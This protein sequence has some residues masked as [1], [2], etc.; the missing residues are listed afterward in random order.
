MGGTLLGG[1]EQVMCV[2]RINVQCS[3]NCSELMIEN[4]QDAELIIENIVSTAL[5]EL[6]DMVCV[7]DIKLYRSL[8]ESE[9]D[10]QDDW[11]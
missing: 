5:L 3:E 8:R 11:G 10:V 7:N 9:E 2:I 1:K 6:F 4:V